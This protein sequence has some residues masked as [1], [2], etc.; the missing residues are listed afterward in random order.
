MEIS[1]NYVVSKAVVAKVSEYK[2]ISLA[3]KHGIFAGIPIKKIV[4]VVAVN[5]II[6][7]SG[8]HGV[9]AAVTI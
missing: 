3:T 9:V 5:D 8:E 2:I 6:A 4:I 7:I 1:V